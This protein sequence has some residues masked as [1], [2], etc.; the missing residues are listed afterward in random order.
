MAR[1]LVTVAAR[2]VD[3]ALLGPSRERAKELPHGRGSS[4]NGR[5]MSADDDLSFEDEESDTA[6]EH[7]PYDDR[8]AFGTSFDEQLA[9]REAV[10]RA[11]EQQEAE[12]PAEQEEVGA[13][14]PASPTQRKNLA[15]A[16]TARGPSFDER[17]SQ[18]GEKIA[19]MPLTDTPI[20][21]VA[22]PKKP[23]PVK[24]GAK[25]QP[26]PFPAAKPAT[27]VAAQPR[28]ATPAP[29]LPRPHLSGPS[30]NRRHHRPRRPN[31]TP[32]RRTS[33]LSRTKRKAARCRRR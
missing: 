30:R 20:A 19:A 1:P 16:S 5:A 12:A 10:E 18:M 3:G 8:T 2:E 14:E 25:T 22:R 24:P 7:N 27:P 28:P 23:F 15:F 9:L 21:G 29:P 33:S 17:I 32:C 26:A 6:L 11:V 4:H 31:R 13:K